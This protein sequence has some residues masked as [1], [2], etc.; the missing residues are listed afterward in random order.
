MLKFLW[1]MRK[2]TDS[3][4]VLW[5]HTYY[6]KGHDI[7]NMDISKDFTWIVKG[8]MKDKMTIIDSLN[9][10]QQALMTGKFKMGKFTKT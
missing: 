3:L 10:W 4:W 1:D 8:I 5:M 7:M 6:I 9:S 2:K